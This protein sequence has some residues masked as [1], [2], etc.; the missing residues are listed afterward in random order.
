MEERLRKWRLILGRQSNPT[1][2]IQLDDDMN[3]MDQVLEALYDAERKG[4]LGNSSPNVNIS[5]N[6]LFK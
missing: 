1:D 6:Q 2:D 5:Q 4:G 3:R